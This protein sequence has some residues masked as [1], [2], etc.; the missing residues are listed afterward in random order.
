MSLNR[1]MLIGNVG[2]DP[3]VKDVRGTKVATFSLATTEKAYTKRDGTQVQEKTEWHNIVVWAG[4]A[5]VVEQ[6][7]R[8]GSKLYVEGKLRTRSWD[9][10][11]TGKKM[12]RA[13][14]FVENLEM[15]GSRAE[16][17]APQQGYA[18][19]AQTYSPQAPYGS[20]PA[21]QQPYQAPA[22]QGGNDLPF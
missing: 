14:V 2:S 21:Y 13:E 18:P 20:Q 8:K 16:Q 19:P 10:Q 4:L 12:Y 22:P 5:G 11:Q 1:I 7:V 9:D 17:A 6:Y 3:E 15:L